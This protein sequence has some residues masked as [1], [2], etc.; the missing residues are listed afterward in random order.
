MIDYG[1]E[2]RG[3]KDSD[4]DDNIQELRNESKWKKAQ[5]RRRNRMI[6]NGEDWENE[7]QD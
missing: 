5:Q 1:C 4:Q 3:F 6:A 7:E 2:Q